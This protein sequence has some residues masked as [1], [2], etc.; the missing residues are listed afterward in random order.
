MFP[1]RQCFLINSDW[2]GICDS[3]SGWVLYDNDIKILGT[4]I[5]STGSG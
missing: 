2:F 4:N 3:G 1:E 5:F